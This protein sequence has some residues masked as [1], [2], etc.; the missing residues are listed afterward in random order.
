MS[1]AEI[2]AAVNDLTPTELADLTDFILDH[3]EGDAWDKQMERDAAAGK[4]DFLIEQADR[5]E[6]EGKLRDWPTAS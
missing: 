1:L 3:G 4:L 6:R 5:A 2:K